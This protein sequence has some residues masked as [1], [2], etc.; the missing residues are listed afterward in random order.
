MFNASTK[1]KLVV[2]SPTEK[3]CF[4]S[5]TYLCILYTY[6]NSLKNKFNLD[7]KYDTSKHK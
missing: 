1:Q 3:N 4:I 5:V 6:I 7:W 2:T